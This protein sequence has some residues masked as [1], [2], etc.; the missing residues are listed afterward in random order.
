M[1]RS[2]PPVSAPCPAR[3][4]PRVPRPA[5]GWVACVAGLAAGATTLSAQVN[6]APSAAAKAGDKDSIITLSPFTVTAEAEQGY[7]ATQTLN[8]TRLKTP[9]RD[10]GAAMTIFTDQFMDDLAASSVTDLVSFA[11]NTDAYVGNISD[12]AG[13]GNEF[14]TTHTPQY[15]TRG[16]TTALISQDFFSTPSIPPDRYN[17]E[18]FTFT[19]GPNAILFGLGNP[20][21]AF[22][23]SSKRANFRDRYRLELRGDDAGGFR[24]TVDLNRML[25]PQRLALRYAGLYEDAEGYRDPSKSTQRR[26]FVTARFTPWAKTSLRANFEHG[27]VHTIAIRPWPSYDGITPWIDAGRPLLAKAKTGNTRVDGIQNAYANANQS[28]IY[29]ADSPAGT[30]V[31]PMSWALQGRSA[32]PGYPNYPVL[33]NG[34]RSL[35]DSSPLPIEANVIGNGTFRDLKFKSEA[36]FL[37]QQITRDFFLEA[38]ISH[39]QS[40]TLVASGIGGQSDRIFVDVNE[41]LPNG[42]PNPNVGKYYVDS[43]VNHLPNR[44][45]NT[46]KRL[47][48]S[49]D[50]DFS[51]LWSEHGAWLGRHRLAALVEDGDTGNWGSQNPSQNLTPLPGSSRDIFN[52]QNRVIFRYYLDPAR[53]V[54]SAGSDVSGKYPLVFAGTPLP[55][56][57]PSGVT[58]GLTAIFGGTAAATRLKTQMFASQ[59][60]FWRDR[61][62][63]T[64]GY[65]QD[66]QVIYRGQQADFAPW[67]DGRG[68]YP[69]PRNFDARKYFPGSRDEQTGHTYTRGLVFHAFK[70]L[71]LSYN[72][73]NNL[74]PSST[75][76]SISGDLLPT[77]SGEGEDYGLKFAFA[78][79]RVVA[80]VVY[81]KNFG[82]NRPDNSVA[83]GLHGNFQNDI[84]AIWTTIAGITGD[85]KYLDQPYAFTGSTWQDVSTGYSDGYEGSIT[86]NVTPQWRLTVNGGRRGPGETQSRGA[87]MKGYLATHLPQ[88]KGNAGWM[89]TPLSGSTGSIG[90]AVGR[91]ENTLASFN[92]LA[93]LP[94]DS[95]LSP[96]W[97]CNVVTAYDFARASRFQGFS[98]GATANLRGQTVIGFAENKAGVLVADQPYHAGEFVTTGAWITYRRKLFAN[99]I[100]WRLQLNVRNVLD[101]NKLFPNR[102][103][104]RRDGTGNGAVVVYRLNEPR[105]FVLTSA[106]SF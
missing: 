105:T 104:D 71:S 93:E 6:P 50:L 55:A 18:N 9:V 56:A 81:Y 5:P 73:S 10:V 61:L 70:W 12:T 96:A 74:Q 39:V 47:M 102:K 24:T 23:S 43:F 3:V 78:G 51:R 17:A 38:A 15:V 79:G 11:P 52:L 29:M 59:S 97:S 88:W 100:E 54:T 68:I 60:H 42:A 80:D 21:G 101:E 14:L 26:H 16:G 85:P 84:N 99:K 44:L 103:V 77:Q 8:G 4:F 69:D 34:F 19:R 13:A 46:T 36:V 64:Y 32:N 53:G 2:C 27:K 1:K 94:S 106:F 63:A 41:Q 86:A 33:G 25:V 75:A 48:L 83:N 67:T 65:R 90:D 57:D 92:A 35:V 49:Y 20:A 22:V 37:E 95:L 72:K 62:I 30:V 76:R 45:I 98:A 66:R 7:L 89:A 82:R 31:P 58:P 28:L 87:L 91:I 40:D